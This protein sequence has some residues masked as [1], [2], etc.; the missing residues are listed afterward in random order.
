MTEGLAIEIAQSKMLE[1]GVGSNYILRYRHFQ[2]LA[3]KTIKIKAGDDLFILLLP[4]S[5]TRVISRNGI[6]DLKDT[7]IN[8]MQY[9]HT[10][11]IEVK[12]LHIKDPIQ[13]KFLQIIPHKNQQHHG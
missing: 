13:V 7:A 2:I 1:L 3:T 8:E 6:H 4:S 11:P 10:G 9:L 12:N 5:D